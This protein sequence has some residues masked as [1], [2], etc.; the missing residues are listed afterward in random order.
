MGFVDED[1][2]SFS[3]R[4]MSLIRLYGT[5][6]SDPK[7]LVG[8][9]L[10]DESNGKTKFC[11]LAQVTA[12]LKAS[13]F[14]NAELQGGKIVNTE[15]SMDKLPKFNSTGA[16]FE[17]TGCTILAES[18]N[19]RYRVVDAR[20]RVATLTEE[21]ILKMIK[22]GIS[23][24]NAKVVTK[25][26]KAHLS[27]IKKPF[28][29]IKMAETKVAEKV[30]RTPVK[31]RISNERKWVHSKHTIKVKNYLQNALVQY[32]NGRWS[33]FGPLR[34]Y[35]EVRLPGRNYDQYEARVNIDREFNIAVKEIVQFNKMPV[36]DQKKFTDI[37]AKIRELGLKER[38]LLETDAEHKER[39]TTIFKLWVLTAGV[40]GYNNQLKEET[41][42]KLDKSVAY[43]NENIIK[44]IDDLLGNPLCTTGLRDILNEF[45]DRVNRRNALAIKQRQAREKES[46]AKRFTITDFTSGK[47]IA[48][49]GLAINPAN[50]GYVMNG[51][52]LNYIG[53]YIKGEGLYEKYKE[54]A[55]GFGDLCCIAHIE[56]CIHSDKKY[57]FNKDIIA[58]A[59]LTM[60]YSK[61]S[62]LAEMYIT[63]H[64]GVDSDDYNFLGK[65]VDSI[66]DAYDRDALQLKPKLDLYYESGFNVYYNDCIWHKGYLKAA[67]LIN[68]R[69]L[70]MRYVIIHEDM[71]DIGKMLAGVHSDFGTLSERLAGSL[72]MI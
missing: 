56:K 16:L 48:A 8:Y 36:A 47:N 40:L 7:T 29:K 70:G 51:V 3:K 50:E 25:D 17:N 64:A 23:V 27:A 52:K 45:K 59:L 31:P 67:E 41:L 1:Y 28:R 63:D 44:R 11:T 49:L 10:L 58:G 61:N 30:T 33:L 15:C 66:R 65:Y 4:P 19:G 26:G 39:N 2:K 5:I 72:R 22:S 68:Y 18:D 54:A 24:V 38:K 9:V 37:I 46:A 60:L 14:I 12:M 53:K 34:Y 71:K 42:R 62:G 43:N 69:K 32:M 6:Y 13:A 55:T 35:K 57:K 20:I 21:D